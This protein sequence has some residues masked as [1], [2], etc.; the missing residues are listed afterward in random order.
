MRILT[1]IPGL[2]LI[3]AACAACSFESGIGDPPE[4][5]ADPS[6]PE[7]ARFL[8]DLLQAA[9]ANPDDPEARGRL[10]MAYEMNDFEDTALIV[11]G[12]AEALDGADFRWPYFQ[13]TL[14]AGRGEIEPAVA[15]LHRAL[16]ID[17]DYA[18]AWLWQGS[19]LRDLGRNDEAG[20][21][22]RRAREL[23]EAVHA[24]AGLAQ[25]ALRRG[26]PA[27]ALDLLLDVERER[28]HPQVFRLL[29]RAYQALD[30]T[31]EARIAMARGKNAEPL[32][33]DDPRLAEKSRYIMSLGG[34]LALAE[35]A[36]RGKDYETAA[37]ILA[38]LRVRFPDDKA[39]LGNLA[40]AY[41]RTGR[42]SQ[43]HYVMRHAFSL[44]A[45]HAPFHNAMA[46]VLAESGDVDGARQQ[47]EQSIRLNAAQAWAH[48]RLGRILMEKG[49]HDEALAAFEQAVRYGIDRPEAVLHLAGSIEGARE[50]WP[51]AISYF[52][53][54]VA[55]DESFADSY[56]YLGIC[57][58]EVGRFDEAKQA[59]AWAEKLGTRRR[60]VQAAR[61]RVAAKAAESG[62]GPETPA[63]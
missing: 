49:E 29:G 56:I 33:W 18:A 39:L 1:G 15:H 26:R 32:R 42:T 20:D 17:A 5:A 47:L 44:D 53:R 19:F 46:T 43:A 16:A 7:L 57:L 61:A 45:E 35:E 36:M 13:A 38:P 10:A 54:A 28:P 22:F 60:E 24:D 21:A 62:H 51:R 50:N 6:D 59:L 11:Y 30:R 4:V 63:P 27:E 55:L 12:Q 9:A 58:A 2:G 34:L 31:D 37:Q 8:D 23:G 25:L 48:E 52:Q 40:I 14:A 3:L 41:A